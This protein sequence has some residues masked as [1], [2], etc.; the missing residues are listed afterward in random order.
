MTISFQSQNK[1]PQ[2]KIWWLNNCPQPPNSN[3]LWNQ[4]LRQLQWR[5]AQ[6][7]CFFKR[8][9]QLGCEYQT[10]NYFIYQPTAHK[11]PM[12]SSFV[13]L[14]ASWIIT[15]IIMLWLRV[16]GSMPNAIQHYWSICMYMINNA[17]NWHKQN[18]IIFSLYADIWTRISRLNHQLVSQLCHFAAHPNKLSYIFDG[19]STK[20]S[21]VCLKKQSKGKEGKLYGV[22]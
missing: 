5:M 9:I 14:K 20:E 19:F 13:G 15:Y 3:T 2:T 21:R 11:P 10:F 17:Q 6:S 18:K 1:I 16:F 7:F 8:V 22:Y 4:W 12:L